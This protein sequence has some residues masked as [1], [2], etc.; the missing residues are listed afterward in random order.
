MSEGVQFTEDAATRIVRV[1]RHVEQTG[2]VLS[3]PPRRPGRTPLRRPPLWEVT[4]VDT[5]AGTCTVRSWEDSGGT[6][7]ALSEKTDVVYDPNNEPSTEDVGLLARLGSGDLF[8]QSGGIVTPTHPDTPDVT[9]GTTAETEAAQTD[10][11]DIG[12]GSLQVT[13]LT[14]MAYDH[15]GDETLYAYYRDFTYDENGRLTQVSVETRV[16]ID[17]PGSCGT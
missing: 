14:R 7:N 17:T 13:M 2:A 11:W 12:D 5:G 16:T 4:A 6:L 3:R 8:F 10:D 9:I 1:V 15:N